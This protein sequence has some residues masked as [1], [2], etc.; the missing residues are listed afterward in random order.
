MKHHPAKLDPELVAGYVRLRKLYAAV[1]A[2]VA[3]EI[4]ERKTKPQ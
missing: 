4:W 3:Q 2:Q 1:I